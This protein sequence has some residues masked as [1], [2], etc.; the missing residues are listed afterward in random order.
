MSDGIE[1]T[2]GRIEESIAA[3]KESLSGPEGINVRVRSLEHDSI[4]IKAKAGVISLVV[5]GAITFAA[6]I[7]SLL[8]KK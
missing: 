7:F 3:I 8:W 1:R 6:T 4:T 2:L 5:S